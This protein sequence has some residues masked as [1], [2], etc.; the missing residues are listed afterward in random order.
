MFDLQGARNQV[1]EH[2][3]AWNMS[4]H[5]MFGYPLCMLLYLDRLFAETSGQY[6][7]FSSKLV[8]RDDITCCR[9]DACVLNHL[10]FLSCNPATFQVQLR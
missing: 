5:V 4:P 1:C 10:D 6:L 7:R 2:F 9:G 3:A 8:Y